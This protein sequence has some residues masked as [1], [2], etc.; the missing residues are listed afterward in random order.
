MTFL[1][2]SVSTSEKHMYDLIP[3]LVTGFRSERGLILIVP[4]DSMA[5]VFIFEHSED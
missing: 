2:Q 1:S 3:F 5:Y 4:V